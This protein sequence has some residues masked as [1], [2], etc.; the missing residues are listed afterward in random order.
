M[1]F[2]SSIG[3]IFHPD[4]RAH[5]SLA[6]NLAGAGGTNPIDIGEGDFNSLVARDINAGDPSHGESMQRA[7]KPREGAEWRNS[8]RSEGWLRTQP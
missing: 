6:E 1:L 8:Q 4:I 5:P 2:R 3:E 7:G